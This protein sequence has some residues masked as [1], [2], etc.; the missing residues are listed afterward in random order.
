MTAVSVEVD[1][2][3]AVITLHRPER[4]NAMDGE[5]TDALLAGIRMLRDDDR[6][7]CMVLTGAGDAFSAGGDI[8]TIREMRDDPQIREAV[9]R[10]HKALFWELTRLP[11]PAIAA[12]NGPAV[13]AGVTIALLCDLVVI[14]EDAFLSDPRVALGLL[15]GAGG[16]VLWPLLTGL[17]AAREHLLL[18]DRV[19]AAEAL[20]LGLAN[21]VV[22]KQEVLAE[23]LCLARRL[24]KLP[25]PAV[26]EARR[27]LNFHVERAAAVVLDDSSRAEY[28][29]FDT[30]EHHALVERLRSQVSS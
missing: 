11:F 16:F 1:E 9:L 2:A 19:M 22:R 23:S 12:V 15:D 8:E 29:C 27:L 26:R 14:A 7:R 13:G 18:G 20:R 17:A 25:A 30:A 5:L 3:V 28:Q 10:A 6:V 21:R 24:A 4:A